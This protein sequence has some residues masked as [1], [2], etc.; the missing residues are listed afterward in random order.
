MLE[1]SA[2]ILVLPLWVVTCLIKE[3]SAVVQP[4]GL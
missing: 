2:R 4:V 1:H 3:C